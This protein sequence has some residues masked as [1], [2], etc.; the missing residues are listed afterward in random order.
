MVTFTK[1][2]TCKVKPCCMP[3]NNISGYTLLSLPTDQ[4]QPLGILTFEKKGIVN[5]TAVRIDNLF[6]ESEVALPVPPDDFSVSSDVSKTLTLEVNVDNHL[7][8]L[9]GLL[10]FLKFSTSFK[11]DKNKSVKIHLL[12]A[13]KRPVNEFQ[14][15]AYISS[16]KVN[17]K[18]KAF[19]EL[20]RNDELYVITDVLLCKK[21][22][23]EYADGKAM[24]IAAKAE[25]AAVG[26]LDIK[27][28]TKKTASDITTNEGEKYITIGVKAYRIFFIKDK[29][30]GEES[31]RIRKD[32]K[33]D[34][35]L[36]DEDFP[37]EML[38]APTIIVT[39]N[40]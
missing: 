35:V 25:A 2:F 21:F 19:V 24:E 11:L 20:L 30:T 27:V 12:E 16:A 4:V 40:E 29:N 13:K 18:G 23:M 10:K 17:E 14:L 31:Y 26:D 9:E 37:G 28:D 5:T 8:L 38:N 33:I 36:D 32:D 34:I 39:E 6:S 7:S 22:S 15:D 1:E 3:T